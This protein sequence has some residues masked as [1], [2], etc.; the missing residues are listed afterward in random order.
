MRLT[1]TMVCLLL[2]TSAARSQGPEPP[3]AT[4]TPT[5]EVISIRRSSNQSTDIRSGVASS[6]TQRAD[7]GFTMVNGVVTSLIGQVY[8]VAPIDMVEL[9]AWALEERYDVSATASSARI[10]TAEERRAMM[11]AL[12]V[13]R[14]RFVARY[15]AR[16]REVWDLVV[17]RP[18]GKLGARLKPSDADCEARESENRA[19]TA[20]GTKAD[21]P[22]CSLGVAG[23]VLA[24]DTTMST[25]AIRIRPQAGRIVIDKTGLS[26][27]YRVTLEFDR[28]GPRGR[29]NATQSPILF[30]ALQEQLG[31]KLESSRAPASVLIID[32]LERPTPN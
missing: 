1:T 3:A 21:R 18:D 26:G 11:L 6:M 29:A 16:E 5:F 15:E 8:Q 30:T 19:A 13:D 9:P 24:G 23:N 20:R 2:L 28:S 4:K 27:Y 17:A 12:L 25:L 7:G 22:P 14:F 32:R 10:P 31:L